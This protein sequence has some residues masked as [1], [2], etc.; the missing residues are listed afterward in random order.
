MKENL[1]KIKSVKVPRKKKL[2]RHEEK[3]LN[4]IKL[5]KKKKKLRTTFNGPSL[6]YL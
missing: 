1:L 5:P 4:L 2:K 3:M 6:L